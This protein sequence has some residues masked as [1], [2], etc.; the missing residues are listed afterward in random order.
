MFDVVSILF[1]S[2]FGGLKRKENDQLPGVIDELFEE[3]TSPCVGGVCLY[4]DLRVLGR[5]G[6]MTE[7][8][9]TSAKVASASGIQTR[10][11]D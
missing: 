9:V 5:K 2:R 4:G 8:L 10:V 1:G 11:T 7:G 3:S 6:S